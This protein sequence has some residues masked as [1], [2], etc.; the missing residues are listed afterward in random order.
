MT[1][2][3]S[4]KKACFPSDAGGNPP[5]PIGLAARPRK[6]AISVV[7]A[8]RALPRRVRA[9]DALQVQA[10]RNAGEPQL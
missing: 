5:I 9:P 6:T 7:R 3:E 2:R 8:R 4:L 1:E 10:D